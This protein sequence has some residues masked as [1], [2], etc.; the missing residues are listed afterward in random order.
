MNSVAF[1]KLNQ[2]NKLHDSNILVQNTSGRSMDAKG[3]V[4]M[5]FE[6]NGKNYTHIF[7]I[8]SSL[9][10]QIIIGQ[11]FLIKYRMTIGWDNDENGKPIKVLKD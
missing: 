6:I 11:D 1:E 10:R 4:T 9:K 2:F 7:I 5:K 8:C 3:K